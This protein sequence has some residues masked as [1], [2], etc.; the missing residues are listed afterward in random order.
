MKLQQA[1]TELV[2]LA[3]ANDTMSFIFDTSQEGKVRIDWQGCLKLEVSPEDMPA[4]MDAMQ[5]LED[6][7]I[8][9]V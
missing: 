5:L 6:L 1:A 2:K 8:A 3:Y 9:V 7:G 4:V